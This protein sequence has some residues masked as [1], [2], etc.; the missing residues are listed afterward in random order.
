[1]DPIAQLDAEWRTI[2][3]GRLAGALQCWHEA[4]PALRPFTTPLALLAYLHQASA[5]DSDPVL[6]ALLAI[7]ATDSLAARFCLQAVLPALKGQARRIARGRDRRDETWELLLASA[8][9]VIR[10]FPLARTRRVAA[11][12]VLETLH[13]ATRELRRG[14]L[15]DADRLDDGDHAVAPASSSGV[16]GLLAAAVADG[17]LDEREAELIAATR[18][19]GLPLAALATALGVPYPALLKRRQRAEHRLRAWIVACDVRKPPRPTLTS[20]GEGVRPD[21]TRR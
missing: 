17:A 3:T 5:A 13:H 8:W 18:L 7:A 11:N 1:M 6:S 12:V 2:A 14:A 10:G 21:P 4:E 16:D 20:D 19:D 9:H 15:L